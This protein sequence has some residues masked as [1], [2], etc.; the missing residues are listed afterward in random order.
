MRLGQEEKGRAEF[1]QAATEM[2]EELWGWRAK[3]GEANIDEIAE[4]VSR[5]RRELMG[6]LIAQLACQYG[7][8]TAI[9][10]IA[11]QDCGGALLY[12]GKPGRIVAHLE[13]ELMLERAY[14]YCA[15][16]ETGLFPP[17]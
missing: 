14:Y 6:R 12:K 17:G 8:G 11:C 7:D 4:Q 16:C 5:S 1:L 9:E 15:R 10:G 3:H 2:Y 13:G